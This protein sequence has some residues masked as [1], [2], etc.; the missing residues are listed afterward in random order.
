MGT[1]IPAREITIK[2]RIAG[3]IINV[4]PEFI[5]GGF[6]KKGT[7]ILEIDSADYKLAVIKKES[8]VTAARFSLKLEQGY[9]TVAKREWE[10][11]STGKPAGDL[12]S[13]LAL[14]KPHLEKAMADMA[15]AEADLN[16][17]MLDLERT[18]IIAPFNLI[19]RSKHVDIGSQISNQG[20]LADV[21]DIDEYWIRVSVSADR[22]GWID[23]PIDRKSSGAPA[24]I[25]YRNGEVTSGNV[26]K[27]LSDLE[28][29]GKM[30]RLLISIKD[31]LG[32]NRHENTKQK[33][34][35]PP[36]LI[37][38]Y[39]KSEIKGQQ[40][41]DGFRIPR[42]ALRDNSHIWLAGTDNK[43]V[44]KPVN[45]IWRDKDMV[46]VKDGLQPGDRLIISELST[47]VEGMLL[48]I[49][50]NDTQK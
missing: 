10:L 50:N 29:E 18:K 30:A 9:Q 32:I 31:P 42:T 49:E 41:E 16:K 44:I 38:E 43:L 46:I 1:V 28:P 3:E 13:D 47:P 45:T 21:V 15:A 27:L 26:I 48:T 24:L 4:H 2:S 35:G 40:I 25:K 14:R 33:N 36:L 23:I 8:D 34:T 39:V 7:K 17:A 19:I 20:S 6:I 5:E 11:L 37:G 22:L 12:D